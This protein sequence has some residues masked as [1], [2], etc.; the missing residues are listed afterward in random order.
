MLSQLI[1]TISSWNILILLSFILNFIVTFFIGNKILQNK[2]ISSVFALIFVIH[3]YIL[4]RSFSHLAL[5]Q[6]WVLL[7]FVYYLFQAKDDI[8]SYLQL[9]GFLLLVFLTS[10][11]YGFF[12]IF[13]VVS[14]FIAELIN[15]VIQKTYNLK[16]ILNLVFLNLVM[17]ALALISLSIILWPFIYTNYFAN[18]NSQIAKNTN[19][20]IVDFVT[21]SNKP[22]YNLF[23]SVD[24]VF[25]GSISKFV[26]DFL[27]ES[28]GHFWTFNYFKS[29]HSAG[30]LGIFNIFM[31]PFM[32]AYILKNYKKIIVKKE[33]Y[34]L[35]IS[36]LFLYIFSLPPFVTGFFDWTIYLPSY[37]VF[38]F[39][40][41]FRVLSRIGIFIF[42]LLTLINFKL[43]SSYTKNKFVFLI[44]LQIFFVDLIIPIKFMYY[45]NLPSYYE[46]IKTSDYD[47]YAVYPYS[48][49][50]LSLFWL[51]EIK[52]GY[53]NPRDFIV[54]GTHTLELTKS[55]TTCEGLKKAHENNID[56]LVVTDDFES[57]VLFENENLLKRLFNNFTNQKIEDD[58]IFFKIRNLSADKKAV[59]YE[60]SDGIIC[61]D[62]GSEIIE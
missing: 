27:L 37:L 23:P 8:K 42:F 55:L 39:L 13:F 2:F 48:E 1:G 41:V 24:G 34:F 10:N 51:K 47:S 17:G 35:F 57:F 61:N 26:F 58:Y 46:F 45:T 25:F 43:L 56:L 20:P 7:L 28:W 6:V 32:L 38:E 3:P 52:K 59:V 29:E 21:F 30:Y 4:Y 18:P 60:I 44:V 49:T 33:F 14:K 54:D 15:Y 5:L 11:Y 12:A 50:N 9:G 16:K 22:W 62:N 40:P 31:L 36:F 19:R 53:Y